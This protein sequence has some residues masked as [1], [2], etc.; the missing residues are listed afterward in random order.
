M[1]KKRKK[2]QGFTFVEIIVVLALVALTAA[3][4]MVNLLASRRTVE[5][6][7]CIN[8]RAVLEQAELSYFAYKKVHTNSFDDLVVCGYLGKV[9]TCP[10]QGV[11]AW[12]PYDIKDPEYQKEIG[13]S[14]HAPAATQ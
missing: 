7:L 10:S 2:N 9:P 1:N 12:V 6:N 14:F 8:N 4:A 5:Y 13:C 3:I 11:Y